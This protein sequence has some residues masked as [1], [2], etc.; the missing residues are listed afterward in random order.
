M[1]T[2]EIVSFVLV[3]VAIF[4]SPYVFLKILT[5]LKHKLEPASST[6][7]LTADE[8]KKLQFHREAIRGFAYAFLFFGV[9]LFV[10]ALL[11]DLEGLKS[12]FIAGALMFFLGGLGVWNKIRW[13]AWFT[14]IPLI[15]FGVYAVWQNWKNWYIVI[16]RNYSG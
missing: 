4:I 10:F 2:S 8:N 15:F 13:A 14:L 16:I 11:N 7:N 1:S 3:V 12:F 5:L 6:L 9:L